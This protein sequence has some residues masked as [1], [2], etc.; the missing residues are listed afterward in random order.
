MVKKKT[1]KTKK[2]THHN[3]DSLSRAVRDISTSRKMELEEEPEVSLALCGLAD[4]ASNLFLQ[5]LKDTIKTPVD[6]DK[7]KDML[8]VLHLTYLKLSAEIL[9]EETLDTNCDIPIS[10]CRGTAPISNKKDSVPIYI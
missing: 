1:D 10:G 3:V 6:E 2:T 4:Y 8:L 7:K 9:E 5:L